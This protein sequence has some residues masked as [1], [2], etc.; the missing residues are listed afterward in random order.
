MTVYLPRG[1]RQAYNSCD[2]KSKTAELGSEAFTPLP[3]GDGHVS[4]MRVCTM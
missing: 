3:K 2:L 1:L 4:D